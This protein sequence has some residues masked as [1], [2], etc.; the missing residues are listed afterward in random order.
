MK[1]LKSVLYMHDALFGGPSGRP[2]A[3]LLRFRSRVFSVLCEVP[4]PQ[5]MMK[6]SHAEVFS[7]D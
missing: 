1:N 2:V 4:T 7:E 3:Q 5:R 6:S